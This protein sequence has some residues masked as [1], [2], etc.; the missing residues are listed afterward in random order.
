VLVQ[1][2]VMTDVELCVEATRAG[3]ILRTKLTQQALRTARE[4]HDRYRLGYEHL[5]K[6]FNRPN[7]EFRVKFSQMWLEGWHELIKRLDDHE[8]TA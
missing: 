6:Q 1:D 5:A 8:N 3:L 2:A 4:K 7:V